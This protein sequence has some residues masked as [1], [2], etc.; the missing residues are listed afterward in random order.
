MRS[1]PLRAHLTPREMSQLQETMETCPR[2]SI[3]LPAVDGPRDRYGG[4]SP[5]CWAMFGE[6]LA[7]EYGEYEYPQVYRTIVDAY[8]AQHPGQATASGRRSVVVHLVGLLCVLEL[9][10]SGEEVTRT[11]ARAFPEKQ[12]IPALEPVPWLGEVNVAHIHSARDIE[13]HTARA[14]VWAESVWRAWS[15]HHA[16]IHEL[17]AR[18]RG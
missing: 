16:R 13:E 10:L 15:P 1:A 14:R 11:L 2:C 9:G 7:K 12:D 5:S 17:L 4:A 8:M 3:Q 18:S 6:V